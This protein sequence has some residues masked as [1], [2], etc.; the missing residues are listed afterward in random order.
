MG[1]L[2][3]HMEATTQMN[4]QTTR[5]RRWGLALLVVAVAASWLALS[6][7][8]L[9]MGELNQDEGWY[10]YAAGQIRVGHLPYRDFAFTQPPMLPLVYSWGYHWIERF[11]VAGGR[12][13]TWMLSSLSLLMT[14]W[15]AVRLGPRG[16]Q[17]FTAGLCVLLVAVN[18]YQSYFTVV[19]KTYALT[20]LLLVSGLVMLSF[21]SRERAFRA[22]FTGGLL[23][24]LATATRISMGVALGLGFL[25]VLALQHRLKAWAWLDYALGAGLGL[26]L[27]FLPFLALGGDGFW[28]GLFEYHTLR[29][30]GTWL[31]RAAY[32]AGALSRLAHAYYPAV[33]IGIL[34][35]A[36]AGFGRTIRDGS[37]R[38][39]GGGPGDTAASHGIPPGFAILLV[40]V[41][42]A[43]GAVHLLAPFPYDDYQVPLYPLLCAGL[44]GC[45]ARAWMRLEARYFAAQDPAVRHDRRLAVLLCFW[46]L[47]VVHALSSP[48]AQGWFV[49]G[50]D[51]IW[52]QL[53]E[54]S[55]MGQLRNMG[56][57]VRELTLAEGGTELLTQDT[58]LAVEAGL[59]VPRGLEMGPFS[60][61]PDWPRER[62][63]R[64]GVMNR[65]MLADLLSETTNAP[66][67]AFSGYGLAIR[68][69]EIEPIRREDR[70]DFEAIL[71]HRFDRVESVPG[72]GQAGTTLEIWRLKK[73]EDYPGHA[74]ETAEE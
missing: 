1:K 66:I 20:G 49:A 39:A 48:Q 23:L 60:Y 12:A 50:R 19:V 26:G 36:A 27:T 52:W 61:Y 29:S 25:Y 16:A 65:D 32:Q 58:Y 14:L 68:S 47:C 45:A 28:F 57:W 73:F 62:A 8:N 42:V 7:M 74:A 10:L 21:V 53:R 44:S 55:P 18:L 41:L 4:G 33:I 72:F 24:A 2:G 31:T 9:W 43:V 54:Q 51:R 35:L 11:G 17:R 6:G 64:I 15:L 70:L 63:E 67:A 40:L 38:C 71:D 13:L 37:L 69:P 59:P 30:A 56:G 3:R 5:G 22:A 34:L 46:L